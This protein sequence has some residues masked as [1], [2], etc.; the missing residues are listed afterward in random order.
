MKKK[1]YLP[2]TIVIGPQ[3][4]GTTWL[5]N[6][7]QARKDILL[8][9][10]TKETHFFDTYYLKGLDWYRS[11]FENT[12]SYRRVIEVAPTYF[13]KNEVTDRIRKDLGII[14]IICTLRNPVIR[15]FSLYLHLLRFGYTSLDFR[16]TVDKNTLILNSSLYSVHLDRWIKVFGR[17]NVLIVFYENL[18]KDQNNYIKNICTHLNI[19]YMPVP[20]N[21]RGKI[22]QATLPK[23]YR[24][25]YYAQRLSEILQQYRLYPLLTLAK[26]LGLREL[27]YGRPGD[28]T[29]PELSGE[30][31]NWFLN[32]VRYD[33]DNLENMLNMDLHEWKKQ[34]S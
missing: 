15:A 20:N 8:P 12:K 27:F 17:E 6:Y 32:K 30:D 16:S 4:C 14:T 18:K 10:K 22:G 3:R 23:Y 34:K 29:L 28:T 26:R 19:P 31:Y 7:L 21:T 25:A 11:F 5:H 24:L 9:K 1:L 2:N 33:I 13:E